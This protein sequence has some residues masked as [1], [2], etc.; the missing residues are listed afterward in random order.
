MIRPFL[1]LIYFLMSISLVAQEKFEDGFIVTLEGDTIYGQIGKAPKYD[2]CR[3]LHNETITEYRPS[4]ITAYGINMGFYYKSISKDTTFAQLLAE[5]SLSVYENSRTIYVEHDAESQII[6]VSKKPSV[7]FVNDVKSVKRDKKWIGAL[8]I[9]TQDCNTNSFNPEKLK[10][11]TKN[12]INFARE[13]TNCNGETF[14]DFRKGLK[15]EFS[16]MTGFLYNHINVVS[17]SGAVAFGNDQ[18]GGLGFQLGASM[19]FYPNW[20]RN[21]FGLELGFRYFQSRSRDERSI[22]DS[23]NFTNQ[24]EVTTFSHTGM[25]IPLTIN[26]KTSISSSASFQLKAGGFLNPLFSSNIE[27]ISNRVNMTTNEASSSERY[28]L[29]LEHNLYGFTVAAGIYQRSSES[30]D[31]GIEA[32]FISNN[33]MK[34][35]DNRLE[36]TMYQIGLNFVMLF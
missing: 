31:W 22:P 35:V 32:T 18:Y 14:K 9:L 34:Y 4:S 15:P 8:Q 6:K 12:I 29:D 28:S 23:G 7:I 11:N 17:Q 25:I 5:G 10:P 16:L 21:K 13:Y 20:P 24:E 26:Y 3:F 2:I 27:G 30:F 36:A 33:E 1:L 19:A